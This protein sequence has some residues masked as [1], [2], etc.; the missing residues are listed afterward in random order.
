MI[1]STFQSTS[2]SDWQ[3]ML[4]EKEKHSTCN[5]LNFLCVLVTFSMCMFF[6]KLWKF[7]VQFSNKKNLF[8]WWMRYLNQWKK[9][10]STFSTD[11]NLHENTQN[12]CQIFWKF[13]IELKQS[14]FC[15]FHL[16]R[17]LYKKH[18]LNRHWC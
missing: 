9:F 10:C 15:F 18:F 5:V 14:H 6:T 3:N 16:K 7:K 11:I 4:H 17:A 1:L 12:V 2:C 8:D 13:L